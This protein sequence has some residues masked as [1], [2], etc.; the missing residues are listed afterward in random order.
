MGTDDTQAPAGQQGKDA[1]PECY[2]SKSHVHMKH[3]SQGQ[4]AALKSAERKMLTRV[5]LLNVL[6]MFVNYIDRTNLSFAAVQLNRDIGLDH[7]TYG[8]GAGLFFC[9]YASMQVP[10]NM[11][12]AKIGGPI[13]LGT[14]GMLWGITAACFASLRSVPQFL[15]LRFL[16]GVFEAGALPGM[17]SYLTHFYSRQR[18]TIP[19]G[20]LMGS[21]IVSQALGAPIAAGLM[22]LDNK[23]GLRGWQ[24]LFL[25]E[26]VLAC[27]VAFA[28][29]FM[30]RDIDAIRGL[31]DD[32]RAA[33]H[34]SM[35]HAAKPSADPVKALVAALKNPAVWIGGG[36]IKFFRDVGFYGL[37]YWLPLVI[38][39]MLDG[40][41]APQQRAIYSVLLTA[42]PF[43]CSAA[44]QFLT[45]WHSQ[46]RNER[47][48]HLASFWAFGVVCL[49][50]LPVSQMHHS[51]AGSF[52]L[53]TLGV[54]G[55][56][57]VEGISVSYYL[58][59]MG[60]EKGLGIAVINA[61][62]ALGGFVGPY[63][64]GALTQKS[65]NFYGAMWM[66]AA[67]LAVAAVN[68][69]VVT[70]E[71]ASKFSLNPGQSPTVRRASSARLPSTLFGDASMIAAVAAYM[72]EDEESDSDEQMDLELGAKP[73]VAAAAAAA[74][75][76]AAAIT[77]TSAAAAP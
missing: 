25:V 12:M 34:A 49:A 20:Y 43:V 59:L 72:P 74:A 48:W 44:A 24:W 52:V 15:A 41:V 5:L 63:L 61:L 37:M 50:L 28:W 23:G 73:E 9:A 51:A 31:T 3:L 71:W 64:I 18:I 6:L 4:F 54:V 65:G 7:Q 22:S 38:E 19:L 33:L 45:C 76:P 68:V 32:E 1:G 21:L 8:L 10:A 57:G 77:N 40:S 36:G 13:W 66:L 62:G 75:G 42:V 11:L 69:A 2:S 67:F 53:L 16:L 47:R 58:A 55:V 35:S 56:F 14:I 27:I 70:E 46:R 29:F 17:W 39:S 60:G 26:G 30:P